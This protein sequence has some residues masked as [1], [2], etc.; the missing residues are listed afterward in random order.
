MDDSDVNLLGDAT[1]RLPLSSARAAV[2]VYFC[3]TRSPRVK[4][5]SN[6]CLHAHDARR[7]DRRI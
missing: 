7:L 1:A 6:V 5:V 3:H 2:G 4:C